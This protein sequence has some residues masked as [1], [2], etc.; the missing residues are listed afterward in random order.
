MKQ[1]AFKELLRSDQTIFSFSEI[2]VLLNIN[3]ISTL[4]SKIH[5][6]IKQGDIYHI[7]RGLYAKDKNYDP[8]ELATKI[9]TPSYISFETALRSSGIIYQ[10]YKSIFVTSYLARTIE[11]DGRTYIYKAIKSILNNS[12]GIQ[13]EKNYSIAGPERAFLDTIYLHKE[14]HFDNLNPLN[15]DMVYELAPIYKNISMEKRITKYF[16]AFKDNPLK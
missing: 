5:Y 14:Y 9:Y 1:R 4:K 7:R 15:W 16:N 8:L 3:K 6:H 13:K 12:A 11:C 10:H 2:A